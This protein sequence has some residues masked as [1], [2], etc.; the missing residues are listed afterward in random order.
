MVAVLAMALAGS[1][2]SSESAL[3]S[4]EPSPTTVAVTTPG[5]GASDEASDE[6]ADDVSVTVAAD[7]QAL[8]PVIRVDQFGYRPGDPKVAVIADR[9]EGGAGP[10]IEPGPTIEVRRVPDGEVVLSGAPR[11]WGGGRAAE[12]SGDRGWWFDFSDLDE[13]GTYYL[14]D[15]EAGIRSH[16]FDV[17]PAVYDEVLRAA[18]RVFW[19]NRANHDHPAELAGPWADGPAMIGPGQDGEARSIDDPEDPATARDL[20]GGW[21]DAGDTNKYVTFAAEPVHA[22]LAAYARGPELFDDDLGI[23]ESGNGIPDIVDE[24]RWETAWMERMQLDDGGVLIK[25]G[26]VDYAQTRIPSEDRQS[27]FYEEVCSSSTIAAAGVYAHAAVVFGEL[28]ELEADATRLRDRAVAA[29]DWYEANPVRDDCDAQVVLSGDADWSIDFQEQ[30]AVL[31]AVYL[32]ALTGEDRYRAR[33]EQSLDRTLP[34]IEDGFGHYGPSQAEALLFHR[35]HTD[36]DPA[37]AARI[38]ERL[39]QVA[40]SS[41][42][43]GF[44]PEAELYRAW[45]PLTAYHWGSNMVAANVGAVAVLAAPSPESDERALAHL[46]YLHGLNPLGLAYLS[47]LG[48][49]GA[50][51]SVQHLFHFWFGDGSDFDIGVAPAPGVPPGYVVGGPNQFYSGSTSPPAGEAPQ[52][53]YA[54]APG[55]ELEQPWEITEPAI[56]YQSAYVRLLSTVLAG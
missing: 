8:S 31:A 10:T 43:L 16:P 6:A 25:V 38:D 55:T 39:G 3:R 20:S 51:R 22:L 44:D 48:G 24:I 9:G 21:F 36:A 53:A 40:P 1:A 35:D 45:L 4:V 14:V 56:Y 26:N 46:N 13:P 33:I 32:H 49:A 11:P 12:A 28:P 2:C 41:P 30:N 47:N 18:L 52:R 23:T 50:E 29:W 54:D 19:Y 27:R 17:D 15:T 5:D 42:F 34:F 37:I 7:D